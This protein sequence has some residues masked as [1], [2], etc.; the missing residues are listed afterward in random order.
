MNIYLS[1]ASWKQSLLDLVILICDLPIF[2]HRQPEHLFFLVQK[3][4]P[5]TYE[6]ITATPVRSTSWKICLLSAFSYWEICPRQHYRW[7]LW[8]S[9][10][11]NRYLPFLNVILHKNDL[12][13]YFQYKHG[14]YIR[15]CHWHNNIVQT[16][17]K[18]YK[19]LVSLMTTVKPKASSI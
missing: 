6:K 9:D 2:R 3:I 10:K 17:T 13:S 11:F 18:H 1:V 19:Y 7:N 8:I 12:N 14:K 16:F 4:A 5:V 15:V